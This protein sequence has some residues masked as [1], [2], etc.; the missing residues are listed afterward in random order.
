MCV[1]GVYGEISIPQ[2]SLIYENL[3]KLALNNM[4]RIFFTFSKKHDLFIFHFLAES[5]HISFH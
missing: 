2:K 4:S 5:A 3:R 1:Y